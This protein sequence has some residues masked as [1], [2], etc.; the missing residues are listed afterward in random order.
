MVVGE[1]AKGRK[2]TA[3]NHVK[4]ILH[5]ADPFWGSELNQSGLASGEGVIHHVR[6][7][8]EQ[9][10]SDAKNGQTH[11]TLVDPGVTDKRLLVIEQEFASVLN[12]MERDRNTLSSLLRLAWDGAPLGNMS[13]NTGERATGAHISL[14]GHIV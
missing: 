14:M 11:V 3:W 9:K 5:R 6:D 13:K 12:V 10:V 1:T 8:R 7:P 2:G 4:Q